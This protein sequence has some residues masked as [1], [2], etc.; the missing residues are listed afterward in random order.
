MASLLTEI[1]PKKL[2]QCMHCGMCLPVCPTYNTTHREKN[3]PRGRISLMRGVAEGALEPSA[4]FADEMSYCLGCLAC[5]TA[6]PAGV[7]YVDLFES[8]RATAE[9]H[10]GGGN[11]PRRMLRAVTLRFLFTNPAALRFTGTLLRWFRTSGLQDAIR[12]SGLLKWLPKRL[13]DL[14]AKTPVIAD[15]TASDLIDENERVS[16]NR[17]HVLMLTGCVQDLIHADIHRDTVDVLLAA[18]CNVHTPTNQSCCGSLHAHNGDPDTA[19]RLALSLLNRFSADRYDAIISN[20]GG[21]GSHLRRFTALFPP[22]S[23]W[24]SLAKTWDSKVRDIHEWLQEIGWTPPSHFAAQDKATYHDSCHLCHGQKVTH[25]PR[26]LLAKSGANM[27]PLPD[28]TWCCGSA[29]IYNLTQPK[30]AQELLEKKIHHIRTTGAQTV[31][32]ANPGCHLQ[33]ESGL[34]DAGL[35]SIKV[36]HPISRLAEVVRSAKTGQP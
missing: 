10:A 8:A 34:K 28:S 27:L 17:Y 23:P 30:Q 19:R 33:I 13:Q 11:L 1:D 35:S 22:H 18:N 6:C 12:R 20:A 9:H 36:R 4:D 25:Q 31:Y 15:H 14:E 16:G 2:Q 7:E 21:C 29:G 26:Q 3:S 5:Q 24:H 32:T